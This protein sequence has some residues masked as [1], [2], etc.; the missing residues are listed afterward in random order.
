M[1]REWA[2]GWQY[3]MGETEQSYSDINPCKLTT[4]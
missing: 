1:V 4:T 2:V 3:K